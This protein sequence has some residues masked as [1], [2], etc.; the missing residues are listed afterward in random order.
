ML[1]PR[2]LASAIP[3]PASALNPQTPTYHLSAAL[4]P[5]HCLLKLFAS[6][7]DSSFHPHCP[8]P[9]NLSINQWPKQCLSSS[10]P[11]PSSAPAML[12]TAVCFL[13]GHCSSPALGFPGGSEGKEIC[14]QCGRPRSSPWVRKSPW[15]R[16]WQPI[17]VFL[18]GEF[19]GQR[20]LVGYS[21]W[22]HKELDMIK[23]L[24]LLIQKD[25]S[26]IRR[27]RE[28]KSLPCED[29]AG[30]GLPANQ[31]ESPHRNTTMPAS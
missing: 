30:R 12:P 14:L 4:S 21:P 29:R 5:E 24:P 22:S 20:T 16:E 10:C 9:F 19:H 13:T 15:R 27:W 2:F 26:L 1:C 28:F 25:G 17:L 18:L 6:A 7:P 23:Q 3:T 8:S 31:E 11:R